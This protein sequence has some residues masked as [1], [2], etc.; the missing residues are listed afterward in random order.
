MLKLIKIIYIE[1]HNGILRNE[2]MKKIFVLKDS[3]VDNYV[4]PLSHSHIF[5]EMYILQKG[6]RRIFIENSNYD[7]VDN[8]IIIIPPSK[9]HRTEGNPHTR[10]LV[11]FERN[12]LDDFQSNVI[13]MLQNQ[14][15]SMT[16][17]ETDRILYLVERMLD[18]QNDNVKNDDEKDYF[19]KILF[20]NLIFELSRLK[21]FPVKK[22]T[23]TEELSVRTKKI[24]NYINDNYDKQIT[25]ELLSQLFFFSKTSLN[26]DFKKNTGLS[27][28][29]YLLKKRINVAQNLLLNSNK[30]ICEIAEECG[31]SSQSYFYLIFRKRIG[32]SPSA[33]RKKPRQ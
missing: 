1:K 8:D 17:Q 16:Q 30:S 3:T 10:Y 27:I 33:Y 11:N 23:K 29:D 18:I 12:Y 19:L 6:K 22:F 9:L 2:R 7:L 4:M 31:F 28:I 32:A 14:K 21:Y 15:T 20:S 24:I 5:F 13:E 25:L 26:N